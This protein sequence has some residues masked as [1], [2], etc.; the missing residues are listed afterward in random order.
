M[1]SVVVDNCVI[2]HISSSALLPVV[3]YTGRLCTKWGI[4]FKRIGIYKKDRDFTSWTIQNERQNCL[5][6]VFQSGRRGGLMVSALDSG[7][8]GP[9]SSPGRG[10]ALGSWA[11]YFTL[12]VPLST[13]V[14]RKPG[15]APA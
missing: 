4:N 6:Q 1:T 10:T 9:G 14:L 15:Y 13:Q 11:R 7:S 5:L 3:D 2:T 12:T 8:G